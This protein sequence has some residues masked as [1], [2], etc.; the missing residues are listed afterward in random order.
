MTVMMRPE[1]SSTR[2]PS[3]HT[4]ADHRVRA[5]PRRAGQRHHAA[6]AGAGAGRARLF[7]D[8]RFDAR[9]LPTEWAAGPRRLQQCWPRCSPTSPCTSA[10]PRAPA[11]SRSSSARAMPA[12]LAGCIGRPAGRPCAA[13][14][15]RRAPARQPAGAPHRDAAAAARHSRLRLARRRQP[16]CAT[17]RSIT[18]SCAPGTNRPPAAA[19]ASCTSRRRW[20]ARAAPTAAAPAPVR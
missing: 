15:R 10:S 3:P 8:A 14:W 18:R 6:A 5:V 4:R 20:P 2:Q 7:P 13:R 1:P 12:G 19:S 17:P 16:T 11:A 9:V